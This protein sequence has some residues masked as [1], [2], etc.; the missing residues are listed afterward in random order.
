MHVQNCFFVNL[1]LL[2]FF[3]FSLPSLSWLFKLH[4]IVFENLRF[5]SSTR[6]KKKP[7]SRK[8]PLWRAF[9]KRS[10]FIGYVWTVGQTGEKKNIRFQ[11]KTDT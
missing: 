11:T 1:T 2:I 4:I 7:V 3:L 9:L 5:S 10:I 8:S 6:K